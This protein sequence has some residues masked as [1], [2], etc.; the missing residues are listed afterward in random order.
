M[1]S[2]SNMRLGLLMLRATLRNMGVRKGAREL[3]S[4]DAHAR[5]IL[6]RMGEAAKPDDEKLK[7]VD[8]LGSYDDAREL[9]L[10]IVLTVIRTAAGVPYEERRAVIERAHTFEDDVRAML[11]ETIM[12]RRE[13]RAPTA[14]SGA[15]R[16]T[17]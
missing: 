15:A 1:T 2:S 8:P 3:R 4:Y 16:A 11:F 5:W 9:C 7:A 14:A 13:R 10:A 17:G 12:P 6:G